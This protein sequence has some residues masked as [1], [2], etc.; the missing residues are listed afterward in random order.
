VRCV[1]GNNERLR[2]AVFEIIKRI[3]EKSK[4][5]RKMVAIWGGVDLDV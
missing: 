3:K 5:K 4:R 1:K 2:G